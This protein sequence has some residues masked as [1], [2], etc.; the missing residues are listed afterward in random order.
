MSFPIPTPSTLPNGPL[1]AL[2]LGLV[3]VFLPYML[4]LP[5]WVVGLSLLLVGWRWMVLARGWPMLQNLWLLLILSLSAMGIWMEYGALVGRDGGVAVL[6]VLLTLKLNESQKTR[7]ALLLILMA[8]FTLVS[9]YFFRQD[10]FTMV[11]TLGVAVFLLATALFWQAQRATLKTYWKPA[12]VRF[13]KALPLAVVLFVVFPRP[14]G[15]LW[16]MPNQNAATSGLADQVSPGT[17]SNLAKDDSVALRAEFLDPSPRKDQLYWRGPV[18][19]LYNGQDWL[20]RSIWRSFPDNLQVEYQGRVVRYRTTVEPHGSPWVLA[21]DTFAGGSTQVR[22]TANYQAI[23]RPI[24]VRQRFEL[25][26][27]LDATTGRNENSQVLALQLQLP[28]QGNPRA[29]ALAESWK[30]L[31][32]ER[33]VQA[34]LNFLRSGGFS[35]TLT[36]PLLSGPNSID[37][38]LFGTKQGFCE[39][40]AGAFGFLMRAAGV[41]TRLVGGYLG[42]TPSADG[43]YLIVRQSDAHVWNEVW[44]ENRGWVRIDPT[45]AVSPARITQGLVASLQNLE[46]LSPLLRDQDS[47]LSRLRLQWDAWQYAW[48]Q[49]VIGY[50]GE[51]QRRLFGLLGLSGVLLALVVLVLLGLAVLPSVLQRKPRVLCQTDELLKGLSV[52]VKRLGMAPEPSE[53]IGEYAQRMAKLYPEQAHD[54]LAIAESYQ[55]L[56]YGPTSSKEQVQAFLRQVRTFRL[57]QST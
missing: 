12:L 33:R 3:L 42:G 28:A 41:P 32:P 40:Y 44:L 19:E 16:S 30:T 39:H 57:R 55:N 9:L 47:W 53:P 37:D 22:Y 15:P 29:R 6:L 51:Q 45:G 48:D 23:V 1:R 36:P 54:I 11:Y 13:V 31:P 38:L 2:M 4:D 25:Q 34:A 27:V 35:Y 21:L 7:D 24:A 18:Y 10:V 5:F 20:Q 43:Q 52:F 8:F 50:N 17:I 49:W 56:R 14:E 46:A 26:A